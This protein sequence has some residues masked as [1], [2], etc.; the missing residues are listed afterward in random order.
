MENKIYSFDIFDTCIVRTCGK[1]ENIF[2]L[3][4]EEVVRNEDESLLRAFVIERKNAEKATML[5]LA[6]D[7]VTIDEIYDNFD[8]T[9]FTD[10]PKEQVKEK[11]IALELR[12]Y[13]P[14]KSTIEKIEKLRDK[15]RI[16]FISDMYLPDEVIQKTL[17]S[18]GIMQEGDHLYISGSIGLSKYTGRLFEYVREKECVRKSCWTHYGD[19]IHSDY[20]I[21]KRKGIKVNLVHTGY[22]EYE[23][24]VEDEARFFVFPPAASVFAGLMR[25]ER[26]GG[27]NDDGGFVADIMAPLLVPFVD[28]LLKDATAKKIR[29]LYFASRDAYIMYLIAKEF[30]PLYPDVEI[31]YL[32]ISTKV[33]Y[34]SSIFKANKEEFSHVL[35][36]IERFSPR[37]IMEMFDCTNEEIHAMGQWFDMD[38]QICYDSKQA[39]LFLEKL[40]KG[41]NRIKL[42]NRCAIK[43]ELLIGYLKQESFLGDDNDVSV[44]L[45]DTGWRCSTQQMLHEIVCSPVKY[46]YWGVSHKRFSNLFTSYFYAEDFDKHIYRNKAFI[47]F[48]ICRNTEGSTLGYKSVNGEFIPVL[49]E[50]IPTMI[51]EEITQN[52]E[53]V[54][55]FA[56]Q[57]IQYDCL[58]KYSEDIFHSLFLRIMYRFMLCPNKNIVFFLSSKIWWRNFWEKKIPVIIK[59]YPWTAAYIAVLY[60]LKNISGGVYKYR[61]TWLEASLIYTYGTLGKCLAHII[62]YMLKSSR[63]RYGV[64]RLLHTTKK[65]F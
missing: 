10:I 29:R 33:V 58:R 15:G 40:L 20:F 59:L 30:S 27:R 61:M 53:Y 22:S 25:A 42:L 7:A 1:P 55:H 60:C 9:I 65:G 13:A 64:R 35:K 45:V 3:L 14:I 46:Y 6:K 24:I 12:S 26:L 56:R 34:S 2:R 32:H 49:A 50:R 28:A 47:E 52:Y 21:P 31:R 41:D 38:G 37:K 5:L 39:D 8:L 36:Y 18:F 48:Y 57:Y 16:L 51:D 43:R 19:N 4:A 11:E 63:L 44:G 17:T 23:T 62:D 54:L